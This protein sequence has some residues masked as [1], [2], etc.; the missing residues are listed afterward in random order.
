M[1]ENSSTPME[2]QVGGIKYTVNSIF[3]EHDSK[4]A[5]A[6]KIKRLILSDNERNKP[7]T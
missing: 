1:Q 7:R 5:L 4:E 2:H 6:D 3:A